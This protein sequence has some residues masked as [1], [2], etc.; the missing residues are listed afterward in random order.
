MALNTVDPALHYGALILGL[1][2]AIILHEVAHG[3][4]ALKL[5]DPTAK[6]AGR[7][8][9]NPIKLKWHRYCPWEFIRFRNAQL[10]VKP[11]KIV[12]G[13]GCPMSWA[14]LNMGK[15]PVG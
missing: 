13:K 15:T 8:T 1:A 11:K 12:K 9:L 7:L 10:P 3:L 14:G 4:A 6:Y 2:I 5:G